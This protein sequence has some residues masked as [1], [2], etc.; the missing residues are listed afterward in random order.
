[1]IR[2]NGI[3]RCFAIEQRQ[4]VNE[5][6]GLCLDPLG[7][8]LRHDP[9]PDAGIRRDRTF[10]GAA[11]SDWF[12]SKR[13]ARLNAER[14]LSF[15]DR[16]KPSIPQLGQIISSACYECTAC[17][18]GLI[19]AREWPPCWRDRLYGAKVAR[20]DEARGGQYSSGHGGD[21]LPPSNIAAL[22]QFSFGPQLFGCSYPPA[23]LKQADCRLQ[24]IRGGN[25]R[26]SR[27]RSRRQGPSTFVHH[28][29]QAQK[30]LPATTRISEASPDAP[31]SVL[32]D[33]PDFNEFADEVPH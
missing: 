18:G 29:P 9:T 10:V 22:D 32:R 20:V 6:Y 23:F 24:S 7:L 8:L 25:R 28:D 19:Q 4:R 15:F 11:L 30:C 16:L 3:R 2:Q 21:I 17:I 33:N 5:S 27:L 1:M 31:I 26:A 13:S 14:L 12:L